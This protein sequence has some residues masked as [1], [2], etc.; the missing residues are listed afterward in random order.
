MGGIRLTLAAEALHL[1]L[2][3]MKSCDVE[4]VWGD[5]G[6]EVYIPMRGGPTANGLDWQS[7]LRERA[8]SQ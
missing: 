8:T 7:P 2:L 6:S 5:G 4:I 1:Q 3:K